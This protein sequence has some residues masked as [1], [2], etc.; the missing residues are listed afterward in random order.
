MS[1]TIS[2]SVTAGGST[3]ENMS[4]LFSNI[5]AQARFTAEE[6]SLMAGLVKTYDIANVSGTT[7]QIPKYGT[8][9]AA[10]IAEETDLSSSALQTTSTDVV[11]KTVG[12]SVLL[13]DLSTMGGQGNVAAEVGTVLGNAIAKKIDADIIALFD[14]FSQ[15]IG[16][17]GT[18]ITVANIFE[19]VAKIR[20]NAYTG[21][22]ACVLSPMQA[23]H[24]KSALTGSNA[25]SNDVANEAM[26][27]GFVGSIAGVNVYEHS[28]VAVDGNGDSKGAVFAPEAMAM[29]LKRDF[30]IEEQRDASARATELVATAYYGVAELDDGFGVE[31][32]TKAD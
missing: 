26:V 17:A 16:T 20:A 32:L 12:A 13:S 3:T 11:I 22:L 18:A 19:A 6:G 23:Y 5:V 24:L 27:R 1:I 10:D 2:K 15:E 21:E 29:A 25:F 9:T 4:N 8:I 14:G 31:L 7:I 28:G 30:I